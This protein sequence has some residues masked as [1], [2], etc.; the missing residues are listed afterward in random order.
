[1]GELFQGDHCDKSSDILSWRL[2]FRREGKEIEKET[3]RTLSNF[4]FT[5]FT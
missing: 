4:I 5:H 2:P 3:Q 1:M